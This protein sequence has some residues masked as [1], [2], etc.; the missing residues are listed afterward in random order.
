[1]TFAILT[2]MTLSLFGAD[3]DSFPFRDQEPVFSVQ[4]GYDGPKYEVLDYNI[5]VARGGIWTADVEIVIDFE[6]RDQDACQKYLHDE[7]KEQQSHVT[8]RLKATGF[9]SGHSS[10]DGK[11]D[12]NGKMRYQWHGKYE[13]K[14]DDML[15]LASLLKEMSFLSRPEFRW[16][17]STFELKSSKT[18]PV[19]SKDARPM[20]L[21]SYVSTAVVFAHYLPKIAKGLGDLANARDDIIN[22]RGRFEGLPRRRL[23]LTTDGT[24]TSNSPANVSE[25]GKS[26]TLEL[27]KSFWSNDAHDWFIRIDDL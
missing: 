13:S 19:A 10:L 7:L 15:L 16:D 5:H 21:V 2:A 20:S 8:N 4:D 1:M 9:F 12:A 6:D 23:I 17:Q 24:I 22:G 26:L 25:D 27:W 3:V 11:P 18:V 14:S